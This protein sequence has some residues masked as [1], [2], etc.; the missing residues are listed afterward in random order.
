[1]NLLWD[2][3]LR[4]QACGKKEENLFFT[5]AGEYS[6]YYEQ[7]FSCM[8][9]TVVESD[10]IELNLLYRFA[11]IFQEILA[12]DREDLAEFKKYFI[13]AALHVLL[14]TDLHHGL[15]TREIY[16]GGLEKELLEG[17]F[18][19]AG[20]KEFALIPLQ[21]Q[22]R[23]AALA[24]SQMET[25]SSLLIFRRSVLILFPGAVLYQFKADR[26]R[27]IL[28]LTDQPDEYKKRMLQFVQDMY[29]PLSYEICVFWEHHFGMIGVEG[30]MVIDELAIY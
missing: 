4:A 20:A 8:N 19:S 30:T 22:E 10:E 11:D 24:L 18:W 6:P 7:S 5:Q 27:L 16:I 15:S 17:S 23:L 13:D 21:K 29:L 3:V 14:Y 26:K 25:G 12:D 1:M 9:E 2:I 28:Y